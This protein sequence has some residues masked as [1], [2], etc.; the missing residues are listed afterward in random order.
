MPRRTY[1]ERLAAARKRKRLT[2][3]ALA[4]LAG[5]SQ[6]RVSFWETD[7]VIPRPDVQLRLS[8]LLDDPLLIEDAAM[9]RW[10][11]HELNERR[12]RRHAS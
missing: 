9:R 12:G 10:Q 1:G 5:T 11:R 7:V 8:D 4:A 6:A 3:K 2:Q